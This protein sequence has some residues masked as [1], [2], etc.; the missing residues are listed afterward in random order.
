MLTLVLF[1]LFL[2]LIFGV[3]FLVTSKLLQKKNSSSTPKKRSPLGPKILNY[4]VDILDYLDRRKYD[5]SKKT[6]QFSDAE[7]NR[8]DGSIRYCP[9][10]DSNVPKNAKKCWNCKNRLPVDFKMLSISIIF[11]VLAVIF[12]IFCVSSVSTGPSSTLEESSNTASKQV[13]DTIIYSDNDISLYASSIYYGGDQPTIKFLVENKTNENIGFYCSTF[14]VDNV[15][16]D[17]LLRLDIAKGAKAI[18]TL[19]LDD[20]VLDKAGFGYIS[21]IEFFDPHIAFKESSRDTRYIS[22]DLSFDSVTPRDF[23]VSGDVLFSQNGVTVISRFTP[24]QYSRTIPLLIINESGQDIMPS[25]SHV[26]VNG[27][28]VSEWHY[29]LAIQNNSAR[30]FD[31]QLVKESVEDLNVDLIYKASFNLRFLKAGSTQELFS[32]G[33]LY[34]Q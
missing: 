17:S 32:A 3:A 18:G 15:M 11:T 5:R 10:C 2:L 31:I 22:V 27:Y 8:I 28:T 6:E 1:L 7:N 33:Q 13:P 14:V 30:Y 24:G 16:M 19:Y 34:V 26:T 21:Y 29:G 25:T 12:F 23:D 9:Y 20:N 4:L